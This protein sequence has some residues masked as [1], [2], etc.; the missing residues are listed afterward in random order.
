MKT[1]EEYAR[2][3]DEIVLRDVKS[4]Q[5]DWFSIDKETF[6]F[7]E[8][9]NKPF[10]LGTRKTGCDLLILGGTNCNE[11]NLDMVFGCLGNDKF[12]VCQ[13]LSFFMRECDIQEV[14]ALYAFK[15]ATAYFRN[16]GFIPVF[17]DLHCKLIPLQSSQY[18][19]NLQEISSEAVPLLTDTIDCSREEAFDI[20]REWTKEFTKKYENHQYN[21]DCC[22]Y[23]LVDKFIR[24]KLIE[25]CQQK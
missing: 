3:I 15:F 14:W 5:S 10:I 22:Y 2:E 12:Y 13:P 23:D 20:I 17:E 7:S 1:Q 11:G 25:L 19:Q 9:K 8:N 16:Q 6:M 24:D 21:G 18:I 4:C